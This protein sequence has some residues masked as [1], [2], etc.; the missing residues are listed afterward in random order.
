MKYKAKVA[1]INLSAGFL[2]LAAFVLL[3]LYSIF[4]L[5]ASPLFGVG[6]SVLGLILNYYAF[7]FFHELG[8]VVFSKKTALE[9]KKINY[10]LFS[11]E[12][13]NKTL[14]NQALNDEQRNSAKNAVY[15]FSPFSREAGTSEFFAAKDVCAGDIKTATLGGLV[16]SFFYCL[17]AFFV[18]IFVKNQAVFCLFGAG[19]CSAFYLLT[20]N[21]LPLDKTNDGSLVM[22]DEYCDSLANMLEFYYLA[23]NRLENA[24]SAIENRFSG[25]LDEKQ[26][27]KRGAFEAFIAYEMYCANLGENA[28]A[29]FEVFDRFL[30]FKVLNALSDEEYYTVFPELVFCSC[31]CFLK[32][33]EKNSDC[34]VSEKTAK[35]AEF[36]NRNKAEIE[37]YFGSVFAAEA[38][39]ACDFSALKILRAHFAYRLFLKEFGWAKAIKKSYEN[40]FESLALK[41]D[42]SQYL[43]KAEKNLAKYLQGVDA[44]E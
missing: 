22:F 17:A 44:N 1:L 32:L 28:T 30:N 15:K 36:L 16:F 42:C 13:K 2:W 5:N 37:N 8:H 3:C 40:T 31:L 12:F 24:D 41:S 18:L 6:I 25:L 29:L 33:C 21:V 38:V 35:Y 19:A 43:L 14:K 11:V 23:Q 26:S 4:S 10:G 27:E 39:D 34:A 9:L 7:S 20:V